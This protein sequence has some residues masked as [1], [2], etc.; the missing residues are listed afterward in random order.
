MAPE[1]YNHFIGFKSDVYSVAVVLVEIWCGD[2][3][4]NGV[5]YKPCRNEVLKCLRK[6]EKNN[7]KN[8]HRYTKLLRK[9]LNMDME[10]RPNADKFLKGF[11][12]LFQQ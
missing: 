1:Q 2:I 3:W 9:C 5:G 11:D 6:M 12:K 7:D 4:E 8:M 10:K